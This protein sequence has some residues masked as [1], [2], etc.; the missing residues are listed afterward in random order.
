MHSYMINPGVPTAS[1]T[2][3]TDIDMPSFKG[4]PV[5]M[6]KETC[7]RFR[8]VKSGKARGLGNVKMKGPSLMEIDEPS[9]SLRTIVIICFFFLLY[10]AFVYFM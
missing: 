2:L 10:L 5:V 1:S 7:H 6:D 3:G 9:V 4:P 8:Y